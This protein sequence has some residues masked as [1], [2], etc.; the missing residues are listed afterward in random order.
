[1]PNLYRVTPATLNPE[2][3]SE[4]TSGHLH[5][6]DFMRRISAGA[7]FAAVS[8]LGSAA[9]ASITVCNEFH[10]SARVAFAYQDKDGYTAAGW[11]RV[12][13][14]ACQEVDFTPQGDTFFYTAD[15]DT[16]KSGRDTK[17]YHWG[18][19]LRLFVSDKDFNFTN[20]EKSRRGTNAEMFSPTNITAPQMNTLITIRLKEGGTTIESKSK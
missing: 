18:N 13:K 12:A 7:A 4:P 10:T 14:D 9:Q 11:W 16:Y 19:K 2:A 5:T 17:R 6:T 1:M 15:S 3:G 20:A 8:M